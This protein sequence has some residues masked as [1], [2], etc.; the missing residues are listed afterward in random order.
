MSATPSDGNCTKQEVLNFSSPGSSRGCSPTPSESSFQD[1]PITP[2]CQT[3]RGSPNSNCSERTSPASDAKRSAS[4]DHLI[5]VDETEEMDQYEEEDE[6]QPENL[7]IAKRDNASHNA[8][9]CK[10]LFQ[11][12]VP[13]IVYHAP[14]PSIVTPTKAGHPSYPEP[15]LPICLAVTHN[16]PRAFLGSDN[17]AFSPTKNDTIRGKSRMNLI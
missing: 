2:R 17:S 3:P 6:N 16:N 4:P 7:V 11:S 12:N 8:P 15:I 5:N 14:S 9:K 13:A 1:L 10:P